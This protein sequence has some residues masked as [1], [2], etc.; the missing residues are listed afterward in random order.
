MTD[1][2]KKVFWPILEIFIIGILALGF[3]TYASC[4]FWV[5]RDNTSDSSVF[6]Y[7]ARV[8]LN[9]GMPYR[10]A[11]D[12]KGPLIYLINVVGLL[13]SDWKGI[14]VIEVVTLFSTFFIMY[15]IARLFVSR[16][17]SL[18][19]LLTSS[20]LLGTFYKGGNL[21]EEYAMPFI[22]AG[23]YIFTPIVK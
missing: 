8:I 6:S 22:A 3:S 2:K 9:G 18:L 19:I 14:W 4:N 16:I 11:F 1:E 15:R 5:V 20:C 13:I 23:I 10:D 7:V 17:W 12:H 21:T